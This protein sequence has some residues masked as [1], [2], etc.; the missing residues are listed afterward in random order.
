MIGL[1]FW[2]P[3]CCG[4]RELLFVLSFVDCCS[5]RDDHGVAFDLWFC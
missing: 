5:E 1:G 4:C 2:L 3:V